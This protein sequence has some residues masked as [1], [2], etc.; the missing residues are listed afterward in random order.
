M[1]KSTKLTGRLKQTLESKALSIIYP[2]QNEFALLSE[3][4]MLASLNEA[5]LVSLYK[6]KLISLSS[7]QSILKF[8]SK[9]KNKKFSV[10]LKRNVVR[11]AYLLFES[12]LIEEL[13]MDIAGSL[14]VGRSRNDINAT[15][16]KLNLRVFYQSI[17]SNLCLLRETILKQANQYL[18]IAMP[19]YSQF[20][21]AQVGTYAYY[22]LAIE[23]ALARDQFFLKELFASLNECPIGAAAGCGTHFPIDRK[24]TASLL[25]FSRNSVN[26]LEAVAN[27]DVAL[28]MLSILAVLGTTLS[29]MAQDYQLWTMRELS[30]FDLPD[31]LCGG[32]SMMPQKR[33]PYLFEVI[34]GK[35]ASISGLLVQALTA[36]HNVPFSNSVEVSGQAFQGIDT[37]LKNVNDILEL[38]NVLIGNAIPKE[39]QFA[40]SINQGVAVATGVAEF[41]VRKQRMPFRQVHHKIGDTITRAIYQGNDPV[42]EILKLAEGELDDRT[43]LSWAH[44][45]EYGGGPGKKETKRALQQAKRRLLNDRAWISSVEKKWNVAKIKLQANIQKIITLSRKEL[46]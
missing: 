21:V 8:I 37:A 16:F 36:M 26:A 31:N 10:L 39:S 24:L 4:N 22:L 27:R 12:Y 6:S 30:F 11:G 9:L 44:I 29:R 17:Y 5:H 20:Q 33:N 7:V 1:K 13:G 25:G 42:V 34:K 38:S 46:S 2:V 19:V 18:N 43:M 3:L 35:S 45:N 32:S 23:E 15:I 40:N 41:L 14:H 28:R